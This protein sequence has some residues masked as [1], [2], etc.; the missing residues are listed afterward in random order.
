[1]LLHEPHDAVGLRDAQVMDDQHGAKY[2]IPSMSQRD[3]DGE[4]DAEVLLRLAEATAH[5]LGSE[6]F[7]SL[8]R[9]LCEALGAPYAFV[10]EFAGSPSR[11][12]S[13]AY[14][15][16]GALQEN[17]EYDLAGT[18]CEAVA[19]G[20]ICHHPRGVA[21]KFPADRWLAEI[22]AES[23]LGVPLLGRAGARPAPLAPQ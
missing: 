7:G 12:R 10:A 15:A 11:V 2:M 4:G 14:W 23:Y 17:F 5:A 22:G 9:H 1:E 3:S 19:R 18:P 6:F 8:V 16:D 21:A 20:N 13:L